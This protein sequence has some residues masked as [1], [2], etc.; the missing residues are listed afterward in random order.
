MTTIT[1]TRPDDWH[2]HLRDGEVLKDTVR[3][4]SRY[5]GRAI[6]MPNTVPPTT[7]TELAL[8]YRERIRAHIPE[9]SSFEPLMT[10]YLTDNTSP[11]EIKRAKASGAV[12]AA[13]LYP[14]GATTNSDS[15]VTDIAAMAPVFAAM[16]EC[17]MLLLIHGEVTSHDIDIFD[18]E[19]VFL[20]TVLKPITL[21]H[22]KLKIVLEH[23]T[24]KDAV[25]FVQQANENVGAT[26]TAHHLLFN[27]NH[28][29]VG[30][31]RPHFYCLPILKRNVHQ[32]ALVQAATSGN[33]KF[34]LGTDSAP[35][36]QCKKE[37][38]CG[39]AGSYTAH[40]AV[41]LYAE[42]F[43]NENA[44]EHLEAFCSLNGPDFY[45]VARNND[46]ISLTDTPWVVEET[47]PFGDLRV[48]PIR[49]GEKILWSV[50]A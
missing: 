13:K 33:K 18:R 9:S 36:S 34:F 27:R 2:V 22:P 40:A 8:D 4:I 6:I 25:E 17:G 12:Y 48:V 44:L 24:T 39:C 21:N 30:G 16:Q 45:G 5:N 46:T 10:L 23:I 14:A 47:M 26:I 32:Q 11:E 28:M 29:L 31:I 42:V 50:S 43:A 38:A 1:I 3:D 7:T 41:E 19:K 37:N 15:G 35:H 20:D 49:A